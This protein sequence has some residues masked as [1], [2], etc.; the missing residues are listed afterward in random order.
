[1]MNVLKLRVDNDLLSEVERK[2]RVLVPHFFFTINNLTNKIG[3]I[4][5][6]I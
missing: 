4:L 3:G 2:K 1:M 5:S 6:R